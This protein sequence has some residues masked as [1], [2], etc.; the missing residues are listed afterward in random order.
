MDNFMNHAEVSGSE[1][2]QDTVKEVEKTENGFIVKTSSGKEME[3]KFV[4]LA[5]GN[6][7]RHLGVK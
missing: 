2:L 3:S 6:K 4:L 1:I 5:T 7:Y